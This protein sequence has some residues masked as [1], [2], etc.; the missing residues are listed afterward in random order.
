MQV[1]RTRSRLA[2]TTK[3]KDFF[4]C[5]NYLKDR[6]AVQILHTTNARNNNNKTV[7]AA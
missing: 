6:R 7:A 5:Q 3:K 4:Y 1:A 2:L